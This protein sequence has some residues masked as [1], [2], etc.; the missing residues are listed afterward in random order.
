MGR[1]PPVHG[2]DRC[3]NQ[4]SWFLVHLDWLLTVKEVV[5]NVGISVEFFK[6]DWEFWHAVHLYRIRYVTSHGWMKIQP[7]L[8]RDGKPWWN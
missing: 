7:D 3:K 4:L 5:E 6:I 2:T 8:H 1:Q